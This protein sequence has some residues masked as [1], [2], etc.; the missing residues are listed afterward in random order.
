M[1][2]CRPHEQQSRSGCL[3]RST[4]LTELLNH[5]M[6]TH[7]VVCSVCAIVVVTYDTAA[8]RAGSDDTGQ[9]VLDKTHANEYQAASVHRQQQNK[10]CQLMH[11]YARGGR[12]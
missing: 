12:S 1:G 7:L 4:V 6:D 3:L 10:Y 2:R 9:P 5:D 8:V 11:D